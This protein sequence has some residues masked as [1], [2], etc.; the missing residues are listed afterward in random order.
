MYYGVAYYPEHWPEERWSVDA[1]LMQAAGVNGVRMGGFACCKI[2]PE[3]GEYD[4]DHIVSIQAYT[5]MAR[6]E[7]PSRSA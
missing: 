5:R 7:L 6:L 4:S 3:E 2:E 1:K